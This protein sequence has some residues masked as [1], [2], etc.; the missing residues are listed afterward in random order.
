MKV[1][2][3][4]YKDDLK[5][6]T[7]YFNIRD[8]FA[9]I[10]NITY[11]EQFCTLEQNTSSEMTWMIQLLFPTIATGGALMDVGD[12]QERIINICYTMN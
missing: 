11:I 5:L 3:C 12:P 9:N 8:Q 4:W 2:L 10:K 7:Y 6:D 1:H